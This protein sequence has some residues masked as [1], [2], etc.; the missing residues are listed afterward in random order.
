MYNNSTSLIMLYNVIILTTFLILSYKFQ[1]TNSL[2]RTV[3]KCEIRFPIELSL[4]PQ[5]TFIKKTKTKEIEQLKQNITILGD[6]HVV[7]Q[8]LKHGNKPYGST[9]NVN[10]TKSILNRYKTVSVIAEY[11]KKSKTGFILG[12]PPPEIVGGVLRDS[13]AKAIICSMEKKNGGTTVE[14]FQRFC[15][16]Q[17]KARNFMPGSLPIVWNELI[18]D[19]IQIILAS[20]VGASAITIDPE[21][22]DDLSHLI[23]S[24]RD[25]KLEPIILIKNIEE[26]ELAIKAGATTFCLRASSDEEFVS[27]KSQLPTSSE[28]VYIAKLRAEIDF[29]IYTEI[30]TSWLLRDHGFHCVWPSP[31]AIYA[32]GL[33]DVY[34]NILALKAKASRQFLSPRQ[35]LMDRQKEGAKE[36]LGNIYF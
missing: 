14:E 6:D 17:Y 4:S 30:D 23:K 31:E 2:I 32:T 5:A 24:S 18:I 19:E 16:E 21:M 11:N 3:N 28:F 8:Y 35:F 15:K 10:F 7:T 12:M 36:F 13:G 34:S 33:A 22:T 29:S 25:H 27:L 1:V 26:A 20:A 9:I